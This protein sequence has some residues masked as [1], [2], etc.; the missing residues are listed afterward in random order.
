MPRSLLSTN[1]TTWNLINFSFVYN[2]RADADRVYREHFKIESV[3]GRSRQ[4][5]G[6]HKFRSE[7]LCG[8]PCLLLAFVS[9]RTHEMPLN[10]PN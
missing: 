3:S 6:A 4:L 1:D 9:S 10:W 8:L 2:S 5:L 7:E